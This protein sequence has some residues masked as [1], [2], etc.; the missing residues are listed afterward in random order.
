MSQSAPDALRPSASVPVPE[1]RLRKRSPKHLDAQF[2][3]DFKS[4]SLAILI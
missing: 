2:V 3:S 1:S 4:N